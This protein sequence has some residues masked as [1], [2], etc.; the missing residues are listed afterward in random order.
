MFDHQLYHLRKD[1]SEQ[2]NLFEGMPGKVTEMRE[3][4]DMVKIQTGIEGK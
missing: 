1:P 3:R 4:V 2:K